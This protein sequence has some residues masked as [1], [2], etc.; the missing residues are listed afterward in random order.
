MSEL[1]G[2][3]SFYVVVGSAA[4]ALIGLQFVAITLIAARPHLASR[5][6]GAAFSTPTIVHFSTALLLSALMCAPWS[7]AVTPAVL[8]GIIGIIGIVYSLIVAR[9]MRKQAA[10]RPEFEDWLFHMILPLFGHVTLVLS[11]L[12]NASHP[13][14]LLFAVAAV[15]LLLLFIG[16]HNTWDAVTYHIFVHSRKAHTEPRRD[17][18]SEEN[19]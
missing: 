18:G 11:A 9:R 4:A 10:Y 12:M 16:I 13:R 7:S 6:A 2:W 14:E 15:S 17:D 5:D 3:E 8:W 1:G 19:K